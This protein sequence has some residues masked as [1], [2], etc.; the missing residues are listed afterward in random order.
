MSAIQPGRAGWPVLPRG[1]DAFPRR[2]L[3]VVAAFA[4]A[5]AV[6]VLTE[7]RWS[8][9]WGSG[10]IL[11]SLLALVPRLRALV[12]PVGAYAAI[13]LVFNLLRARADDLGWGLASADLVPRLEARLFGGRLP[14]AILQHAL[15]DPEAI[16]APDVLLTAVHLSYF[17]VPIAVAAVLLWRDPARFRRYAAASAVVFAIGVAGATLAPTEPP[18][19]AAGDDLAGGGQPVRR[20]AE[21]VL[22]RFGLP[23]HAGDAAGD[24]QGIA[25]EPNPIA[26]MPS[27]HLAVTV[28]V[29][30]VAWGAGRVWR[31][32][33][34][35]YALLMALA[36][37]Y[38]GEHYVLDV[39]AGALAAWLGWIAS[40][41]AAR[42]SRAHATRARRLAPT[43]WP[44]GGKGF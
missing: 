24:A 31:L 42:G 12:R 25:F 9:V 35:A 4:L 21:V 37:V 7:R 16:H 41:L 20:V 39:A 17:V 38:L 29:V 13:W 44:A 27:I 23:L 22:A 19:M 11:V 8:S 14:T 10:A 30:C 15:F 26:S 1:W 2:V 18:W 33:A 32:A 5:F 43:A 6:D 34:V 36:L 3:V 28:L 40:G